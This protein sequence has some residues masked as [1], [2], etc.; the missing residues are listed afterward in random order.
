MKTH[1][2]TLYQNE[3]DSSPSTKTEAKC[4]HLT[5]IGE[6]LSE[7]GISKLMKT[8]DFFRKEIFHLRKLKIGH[9]KQTSKTTFL[10]MLNIWLSININLLFRKV[11]GKSFEQNVFEMYKN[12][13]TDLVNI[14]QILT[15][16]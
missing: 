8:L 11:S 15:V 3:E 7:R 14:G 4:N 6:S 9:T 5:G 12:P 2:V 16:K 10:G 13:A 1:F